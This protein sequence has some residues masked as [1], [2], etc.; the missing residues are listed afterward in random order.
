MHVPT[1]EESAECEAIRREG[2]DRLLDTVGPALWKIIEAR[3]TQKLKEILA[4]INIRAP[5]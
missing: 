5:K 4:K 2:R 3:R 1:P